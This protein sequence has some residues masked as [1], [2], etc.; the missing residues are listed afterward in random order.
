MSEL[1]FFCLGES[2]RG[3]VYCFLLLLNDFFVS[4]NLLL[5]MNTVTISWIYFTFSCCPLAFGTRC[6]CTGKLWFL[7]T[8]SM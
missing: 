1:F 2:S 8:A 4:G 6:F 3:K 7:Y 5:I